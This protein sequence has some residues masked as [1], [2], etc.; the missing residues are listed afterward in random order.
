[1]A[2]DSKETEDRDSTRPASGMDR[3]GKTTAAG[4][5]PAFFRLHSPAL[6]DRLRK[7]IVTHTGEFPARLFAIQLRWQAVWRWPLGR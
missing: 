7:T 4:Q 2:R 3:T 5:V 1:M 6:P